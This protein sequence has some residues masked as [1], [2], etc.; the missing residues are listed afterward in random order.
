MEKENLISLEFMGE[1]EKNLVKRHRKGIQSSNVRSLKLFGQ[2]GFDK[3]AV[4]SIRVALDKR[5]RGLL[6]YS[7]QCYL[8]IFTFILISLSTQNFTFRMQKFT[9]QLENITFRNNYFFL[10]AAAA[11]FGELFAVG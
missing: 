1:F 11:D 2:Y 9:N 4:E 10:F 7:Q 5:N 8:F 3:R 6:R